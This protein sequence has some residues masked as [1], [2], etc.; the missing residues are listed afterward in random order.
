MSELYVDRASL[1][2]A[3]SNAGNASDDVAGVKITGGM[4]D[5]STGMPGASALDSTSP[6]GEAVD[7]MAKKLSEALTEY[8]TALT[9]AM[10]SYTAADNKTSIDFA[11]FDKVVE[12]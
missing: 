2:A 1:S 8:S 12:G 7:A 10:E 5:V 9:S 4:T 3:A 11:A 6:V